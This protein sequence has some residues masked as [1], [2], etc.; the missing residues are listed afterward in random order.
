MHMQRSKRSH[1]SYIDK[2]RNYYAAQGYEQPYKWAY[3]HETPFSRLK[4]PLT[5]SVV[6]I[7]TTAFFPK[8]IEPHGVAVAPPKKPY[9]APSAPFPTELNTQDLAWDKKAT[10]TEDINSYLP[11]HQLEECRKEGLIAMISPR[12]Y[13]IPTEYSQRRTREDDAPLLLNWCREDGVDAVLLV[14]L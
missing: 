8:G 6:G 1:L 13:G 14:P 12:F 10:H 9:A 7:V 11:L 5:E 3:H 4:K 2:S